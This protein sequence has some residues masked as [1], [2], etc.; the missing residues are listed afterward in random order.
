MRPIKS[1]ISSDSSKTP[2]RASELRRAIRVDLIVYLLVIVIAILAL[3]SLHP[4][5]GCDHAVLGTLASLAMGIITG[6]LAYLRYRANGNGKRAKK[7]GEEESD[8]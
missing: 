1:A 3:A 7:T 2:D 8:E 4:A 5:L 6:T